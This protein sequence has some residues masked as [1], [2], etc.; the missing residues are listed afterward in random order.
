M[1]P[2]KEASEKKAGGTYKADRDHRTTA[3]DTY[4][5]VPRP[6]V[7]LDDDEM[8]IWNSAWEH[9]IRERVPTPT[10]GAVVMYAQFQATY[11]RATEKYKKE[12]VVEYSN[13]ATAK[14]PWFTIATEACTQATRL[15]T[16]I[17]L[18]VKAMAQISPYLK[19]NEKPD[20]KD[21][22]DGF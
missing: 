11:Y 1:R 7:A 20:E 9:L 5:S 18:T 3:A 19:K 21:I 10:L 8:R 12:P 4:R 13:G 2:K 17:G 14:S 15:S 6:P 16:Q 22:L